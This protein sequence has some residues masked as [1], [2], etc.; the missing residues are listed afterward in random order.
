MKKELF[1]VKYLYKLSQYFLNLP[2]IVIRSQEKRFCSKVS[3]ILAKFK[4]VFNFKVPHLCFAGNLIETV[5]VYVV[6][7]I[8]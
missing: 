1:E 3:K 5:Y 6:I 4:K 8:S 7:Y 2:D